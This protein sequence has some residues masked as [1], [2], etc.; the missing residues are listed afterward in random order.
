MTQPELP[1]LHLQPRAERRLR[2]GHNWV[3]SNEVDTARSPLKP[4]APGDEVDV[5]SA[6]GQWLGSGYVNPHT[7]ICARLISRDR[8]HRL[9]RSLLIHRLQVA[10]SLRE[11]FFARPF[12]RLVYG[13]SDSLPGL[14][15]D[16]YGD[17][18]VVQI[19]TAGMERQREALLEALQQV[20]RPS[21]IL[22]KNDSRSR[23]GEQL[24]TYVES[25]LGEVPELAELE[26][27]GVRFLAP[28][29]SGQKTGW[30][31]DHRAARGRLAPYVQGRSVLDVF[32]Y[33]GGWGIQAACLGASHVTCLDSSATALEG[34]RR[35]AGLNG[36]EDRVETLEG[37]AFERLKELADSG[38]RFDTIILD[39]PAFI[40]RRKDQKAGEQAYRRI[41]ELGLRL[42]S[43]D[44][45]LISAS[46]SLHLARETLV[47]VL[48]G[49]ARH[50]DRHLQILEHC[51]QGV[52]H[53]VH[54]S[55][56]ETDYLKS[57]F[58][59]VLRHP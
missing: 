33:I 55:I 10:L 29:A 22:L 25:A 41:N 53:P 4:F 50:V 37:S 24:P 14:V 27:N 38:A 20:L 13:D 5:F 26:E 12:Y 32:S 19:S 31:Y 1:A 59:R 28:L 44:G 18:L 49:A 48:R 58:T 30:F 9:G 17:V 21:A 15:V 54:P 46:C 36:V 57:V 45:C 16:R 40:P 52:D 8:R 3:Y 47:D 43:E 34:V 2:G 6:G 11:R 42:L 51:G 23:A 56:P 39:P 7:L 35:N